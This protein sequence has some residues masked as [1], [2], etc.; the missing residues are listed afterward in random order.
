MDE[1]EQ[2]LLSGVRNTLFEEKQKSE[3]ENGLLFIPKGNRAQLHFLGDSGKDIEAP[4]TCSLS[5]DFSQI[6]SSH[7]A[8]SIL[9]PWAPRPTDLK[10]FPRL[11]HSPH[12]R[13]SSPFLQLCIGFFDSCL[14]AKLLRES[15]RQ[16]ILYG[17]CGVHLV[18][19]S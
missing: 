9:F 4:F 19:I 7:H 15:A 14:F 6:C 13:D 5:T 1:R 10:I 18:K 16:M 17:R 3:Q 2:Y 12:R 11:I 8:C